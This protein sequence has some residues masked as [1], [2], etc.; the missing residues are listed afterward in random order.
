M[1][2][3]AR[4]WSRTFVLRSAVAGP[5]RLGARRAASTQAA[6][7]DGWELVVGLEIHAQLR[8][9]RKLFSRELPP[10]CKADIRRAP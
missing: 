5:Y 10:R 4:A 7:D 3:L 1:A 9:G 8:T 2:T 6:P